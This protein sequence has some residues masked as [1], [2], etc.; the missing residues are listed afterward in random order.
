MSAWGR[1]EPFALV[2]ALRGAIGQSDSARTCQSSRLLKRLAEIGQQSFD[3][4]GDVAM[5]LD[6]ARPCALPR[7]FD[8]RKFQPPAIGRRGIGSRSFDGG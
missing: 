5:P 2:R 7:I 1:P 6:L 4:L 8:E 3:S